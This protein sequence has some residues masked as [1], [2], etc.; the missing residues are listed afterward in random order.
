[1]NISEYILI[2]IAAVVIFTSFVV[3][4]RKN[5]YIM[6]L[7][8]PRAKYELDK[9]GIE[10][11]CRVM[12]LVVAIW[13]VVGAILSS[14]FETVFLVYGDQYGLYRVRHGMGKNNNTEKIG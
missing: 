2:T 14:D 6:G 9:T 10:S 5:G 3:S 8:M 1:M 13:L 4:T 12:L 11:F 7:G